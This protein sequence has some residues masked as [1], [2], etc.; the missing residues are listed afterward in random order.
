MHISLGKT[1][2]ASGFSN[3]IGAF[4]LAN[5]APFAPV[6]LN[7]TVLRARYQVFIGCFKLS[8]YSNYQLIEKNNGLANIAVNAAVNFNQQGQVSDSK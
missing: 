4:S 7:E 5:V 3:Y 2:I 1:E 8:L 6:F